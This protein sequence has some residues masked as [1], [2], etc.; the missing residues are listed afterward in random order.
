MIEVAKNR[1]L[2]NPMFGRGLLIPYASGER[3]FFSISNCI[4]DSVKKYWGIQS[5]VIPLGTIPIGKKVDEKNKLKNIIW[6]GNVKA[7]KRPQYLVNIAKTFSNLQ[8]KMIGD[9]DG[10]M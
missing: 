2:S 1:F 7:N 5:E 3:S 8:F 10:E 9:G 6:V 4:A